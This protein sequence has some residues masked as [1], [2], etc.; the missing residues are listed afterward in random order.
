LIIDLLACLLLIQLS[1]DTVRSHSI[2]DN[3]SKASE[4][5][6]CRDNLRNEG[7]GDHPIRCIGEIS[8]TLGKYAIIFAYVPILILS[9][10]Y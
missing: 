7:Y 2:Q 9:V 1:E 6:L 8:N 10:F 5:R 4:S 3:F